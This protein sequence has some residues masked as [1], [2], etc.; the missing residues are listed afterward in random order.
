MKLT[1]IRNF[2]AVAEC[3]SVQAAARELG[4]TQPAVTRSIRDMEQELGAPLFERSVSGMKVTPVG[5]AVRRRAS[6]VQA[7]IG[8][9]HD[10]VAQ[11]TGRGSGTVSVGLSFVAHAG[12]L[13]KVIGPFR[14]TAPNVRLEIKESLYDAMKSDLDS[15]VIDFYVGP[16]RPGEPHEG[17]LWIEPLFENRRQIYCRRNHALANAKSLAD[18]NGASWVTASATRNS[19]RELSALF[20]HYGLPP[21][22]VAVNAQ[23]MLSMMFIAGSSDL[24]TA[25]PQQLQKMLSLNSN[26]VRIPVSEKLLPATICIVRRAETPLTPAAEMLSDLFRRTAIAHAATLPDTKSLTR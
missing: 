3:G 11:L 21:P 10:E 15:G 12:L 17:K 5:Q 24:L 1:H 13:P 19:Q 14:R 2:L 7:E 18:L 23:T 16:M 22:H 9:I 26:L 25:L 20:S 6:G 4:I 8:R